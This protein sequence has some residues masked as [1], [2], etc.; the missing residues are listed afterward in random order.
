VEGELRPQ[1]ADR[2]GLLVE[3]RT[4]VDPAARAEVI[5]RR[6]AFDADPVGFCSAWEEEQRQLS[7][8]IAAARALF[9]S[10]VLS[11]E[12]IARI[13]SV[14]CGH[15]V[16]GHRADLAIG[17]AA[18]ALA[19]L[20]NRTQV[21]PED[22]QQAA[23][24]V[25]PHRMR[26]PP[27]QPPQS[28]EKPRR[29]WFPDQEGDHAEEPREEPEGTAGEGETV[30]PPGQAATL[31]RIEVMG[32]LRRGEPNRGSNPLPTQPRGR[33]VRAVR[34]RIDVTEALALDA[35]LRAAVLRG[36]SSNGT[37]TIQP[38]D[39]HR[40][41]REDRRGA[42]V[43]F[44]VDA[45][46][47]MGARRRMEAVKAVALGLLADAGRLRDEVAVIAVRGPRAE[48][49]LKPTPDV[50]EAERALTRLPTGG[51]TP[52]AHGLTLAAE[53][54]HA[55]TVPVLLVVVSD[56]KANVALP[57]TEADPWAQAL[58]A[59]ARFTM[60]N[61]KAIVIDADEGFVRAGKARELAAALG[62]ECLPLAAL[63]ADGLGEVLRDPRMRAAGGGS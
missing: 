43:V 47:S 11:D 59:C 57:G 10:V 1:L 52:L 35:T 49:L 25:L 38:E 33:S 40:R 45:S 5:R 30:A 26:R 62:S 15:H 16:E 51:R 42:L 7:H 12:Q 34:G 17:R 36:G 46:G 44:V 61:L 63:S 22:L 23:E 53:L 3:V 13:A 31:P 50:A 6:L 60:P 32:D 27:A 9:G 14:C 4:S 2:F 54:T 8:T 56:G 29:E 39:I 55:A 58:S 24:L 19:A 48:F 28:D 20:A 21:L 18:R 37:I 41:L